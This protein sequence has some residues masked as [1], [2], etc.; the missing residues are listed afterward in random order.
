M[1]F[2]LSIILEYFI[3]FIQFLFNFL[4]FIKNLLFIANYDMKARNYRVS[5]IQLI[6]IIVKIAIR[7]TTIK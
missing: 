6:F 4:D 2:H 3:W 1:V 7:V 5:F